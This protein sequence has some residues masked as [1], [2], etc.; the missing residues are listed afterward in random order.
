MAHGDPS[1]VL[2]AYRPSDCEESSLV[3]MS[4]SVSVVASVGSKVFKV[5]KLIRPSRQVG[6]L[7][8]TWPI[9]SPP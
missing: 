7:S 9:I 5:G 6:R 4:L 3:S 2:S 8:D 1:H